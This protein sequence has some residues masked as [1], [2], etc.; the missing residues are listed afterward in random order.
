MLSNTFYCELNNT[1]YRFYENMIKHFFD[2]NYNHL[3]HKKQAYLFKK[4]V[5]GSDMC[6]EDLGQKKVNKVSDASLLNPALLGFRITRFFG[7]R[8]LIL[9]PFFLFSCSSLN[10]ITKSRPNL[11]KILNNSLMKVCCS[12][13]WYVVEKKKVKAKIVVLF[14]VENVKFR[15]T[16]MFSGFFNNTFSIFHPYYISLKYINTLFTYC[17]HHHNHHVNLPSLFLHDPKIGF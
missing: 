13:C 1:P 2:V 10:R 6:T 4:C 5:S 17:H 16:L 12:C 11:M 3:S 7:F 8:Y 9:N 14:Q 15:M